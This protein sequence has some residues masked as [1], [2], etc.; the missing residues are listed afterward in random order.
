MPV[1]SCFKLRTINIKPEM[2]K[3]QQRDFAAFCSGFAAVLH[4]VGSSCTWFMFIRFYQWFWLF[5]SI[6]FHTCVHNMLLYCSLYVSVCFHDVFHDMFR[7]FLEIWTQVLWSYQ[8][9]FLAPSS[10]V[11][12]TTC[13]V[14]G[15]DCIPCPSWWWSW[16]TR[17]FAAPPCSPPFHPFV[18]TLK[19]R[20]TWRTSKN[21]KQ[22]ER[23]S[24]SSA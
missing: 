6:C 15:S 13:R 22:V 17:T 4:A 16:A 20:R 10:C 3:E 11:T 5:V 9:A 1:S 19:I 12:S 7:C 2:P 8:P 14:G 23:S 18:A 24:E 21:I